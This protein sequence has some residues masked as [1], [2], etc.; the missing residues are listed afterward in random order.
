MIFEYAGIVTELEDRTCPHCHKPLEPWVAPPGS[1]WGVIVVCN[2]NQCPH[3]QNSDKEIINK[4]DDSNLGCRYAENPDNGY[5][6]FN[7]VA[8]CHS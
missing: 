2:N 3:F 6:P 4:R 7:L 5:K 8:L 1:G